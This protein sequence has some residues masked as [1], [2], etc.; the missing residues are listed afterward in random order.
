MLS[1]LASVNLGRLASERFIWRGGSLICEQTCWL[2]S[3]QA[4]EQTWAEAEAVAVKS[5]HV[6]RGLEEN[7]S[8]LMWDGSG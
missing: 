8:G 1:P 5:I 3:Q 2:S 7:L 4:S 6:R